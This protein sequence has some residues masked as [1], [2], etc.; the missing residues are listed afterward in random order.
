MVSASTVA[1]AALG[2]A[3]SIFVVRSLGIESYGAFGILAS[4]AAI[5]TNLLDVRLGDLT[6]RRFFHRDTPGGDATPARGAILVAGLLV[7]AAIA[8]ALFVA[9]SVA[10]PLTLRLFPERQPVAGLLVLFA[11]GE[12]LTYASHFLTFTI[13]LAERFAFLAGVQ[14]LVAFVRAT[15]VIGAVLV[16]P[17]LMGLVTGLF[18]AGLATLLLLLGASLRLWIGESR[19]VCT[20]TETV[21]ALRAIVAD[22]RSLLAFNAMNYQNLLHRAADV[23]AVGLLAGERSAGLYKLARTATDALYMLYDSA[24]KVYQPLLMRLLATHALAA[25]RRVSTTIVTIAAGTVGVALVAEWLVLER[26]VTFA[27][28]PALVPAVPS[29]MVLTVPLFFVGGLYLWVWPLVLH[30]GEVRAYVGLSFASVLLCQ[31]GVGPAAF[32][33]TG[34][35]SVVWLAFGYL[36]SY[37]ALYAGLLARLL[38]RHADA[39]PILL[40]RGGATVA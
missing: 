18:L 32:W 36:L 37:V 10:L 4:V 8:A 26:L 7:Q 31:Y 2:F 40:A 12:A 3:Q 5:C 35:S 34:G 15:L 6:L 11:A 29:I 21:T 17:T 16:A 20:A 25:F 19:L 23:L 1:A 38:R 28:G 9:I 27:L 13:R 24:N 14:L 22:W 33:W 39:L 30:T